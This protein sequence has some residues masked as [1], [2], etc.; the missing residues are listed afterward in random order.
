MKLF[1]MFAMAATALVILASHSAQGE[2]KYDRSW[3]WGTMPVP[4]LAQAPTIDGTIDSQEWGGASLL[5]PLVRMDPMPGN[6]LP[7]RERTWVYLGYTDDALYVAWRQDLPPQELPI[8]PK[9]TDKRDA[10]EARDNTVNIWFGKQ[11]KICN[12]VNISGNP[13]S[14]IY[15][16]RFDTGEGIH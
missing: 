5:P 9:V 3:R 15:D 8:E 6:G 2:E 12:D 4:R 13:A 10:A 16:R 14:Q 11:E 1:P 7:P